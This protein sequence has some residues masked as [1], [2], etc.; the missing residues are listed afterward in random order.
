MTVFYYRIDL[1]TL[2]ENKGILTTVYYGIPFLANCRQLRSE[3]NEATSY[4]CVRA[5]ASRPCHRVINFNY[6]HNH[7]RNA[8][9]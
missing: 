6:N 2:T 9:I 8:S 3:N 7:F 1:P 4:Y 5:P